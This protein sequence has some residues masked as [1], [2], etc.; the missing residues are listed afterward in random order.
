MFLH[1]NSCRLCLTDYSAPLFISHW[2]V[3]S[4]IP[5]FHYDIT[6]LPADA[7]PSSGEP[8]YHGNSHQAVVFCMRYKSGRITPSFISLPTFEG[9]T[10]AGYLVASY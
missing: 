1:G 10:S 9:E 3:S 7:P 8:T 4:G 5:F 2:G 6:P